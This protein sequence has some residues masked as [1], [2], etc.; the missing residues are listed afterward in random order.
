M[1]LS[2]SLSAAP[3]ISLAVYCPL[4]S[5][6]KEER[7]QD[8]ILF[9][10]PPHTNP[11]K[12]MNQVGFCIAMSSLAGRFGVRFSNRQTI[13]KQRSSV[14]LCSPVADLWASAHVRGGYSEAET[15]HQLLQLSFALFELLYGRTLLRLLTEL[16]CATEAVEGPFDEAS[17]S[18]TSHVGDVNEGRARLQSFFTKCAY[19]ISDVLAAQQRTL[20]GTTAMS[21]PPSPSM[22]STQWAQFLCGE[23]ILGFPLHHVNARQLPRRQLGGVEDAVHRVLRPR[24]WA[25]ARVDALRPEPDELPR[26]CV[27]CLPSLYVLMADSRLSCRV[28]QAV[29]FYLVLY[30][31]IANS[32]FRCHL[33][34]AGPCD[35]AVWREENLLVVILEAQRC[36]AAGLSS[37]AEPTLMNSTDAPGA[38]ATPPPPSASSF[39]ASLLQCASAIGIEVRH[40]LVR[41][42][43]GLAT[44]TE[45]DEYWLSTCDITRHEAQYTTAAASLSPTSDASPNVLVLRLRLVGGVVEGTSLVKVWPGL[46]DHIRTIIHSTKLTMA[47]SSSGDGVWG[48][49][50]RWCSIWIYLRFAGST[51]AVLAWRSPVSIRLLSHD[52]KRALLLP[53]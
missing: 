25:C 31:P 49:W 15:T 52:A 17:G 27:F 40:L 44:P 51:V 37:P 32:S 26:C 45:R 29:K 6:D 23:A 48:C 46:I 41:T 12:Q 36:Q 33:P 10:F 3:L 4:L 7:A 34:G 16:P 50:T 8:N 14:C 18:T 30:A 19:F 21:C 22:T 20:T 1:S 24:A 11:S 42:T 9:F 43:A 2:S 47:A 28:L 35:V 39:S 38:A 5:Q 53:L 13:R